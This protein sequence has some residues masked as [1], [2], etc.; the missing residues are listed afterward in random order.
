MA[1]HE[2][3]DLFGEKYKVNDGIKTQL[4]SSD[5][6]LES[7]F[8][9]FR[10]RGF[11]Y[12][13][14]PLFKCKMEL[15]KLTNLTQKECLNSRIGYRIADTYN[16]HRFHSAAIGMNSPFDSFNNDGRLKK[17]L[18]KQHA[19]SETFEYGYLGFM[20]L[21]NGTQACSNFR[22]G[23]ARML[24]NKYAPKDG[25][26]FDS[27]TG[28]GGRLVG[29]LASHCKEYFGTDPNTLTYAANV[30]LAEDLKN[31]KTVHLYNSPIEDLNVDHILEYCDFSFTSPPYFKKEIYSK[32]DTQSCNRYSD[33]DAWIEGFL[34]PMIKQQFKVLKDGA[35]CIIN[36]ED[37]KINT[38]TYPL[39]Q[40]TIDVALQ[41]GFIHIENSIFPM[42][43]R[44]KMVE[45]V[46]VI[47]HATET[48]IVLKKDAASLI[49]IETKDIDTETTDTE[50]KDSLN[51]N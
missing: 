9:D 27:S 36:I 33:Y 32:E 30:R 44:T 17:V 23:F 20:S 5:D 22:P 38:K 43:A 4:F 29:F 7:A 21:V 15:N 12:P 39:V 19:S 2:N 31:D 26:V 8:H 51:I 25:I 10:E 48:V 49:V 6:I 34:T 24:Y 3:E 14:L 47:E 1:E 18:Q 45:G 35:I 46:K 42:Q 13:H 28:Y 16:R 41:N 11:P 37:V 50:T 40:P